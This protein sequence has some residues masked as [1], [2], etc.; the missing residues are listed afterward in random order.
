MKK[1][2]KKKLVIGITSLLTLL[3]GIFLVMNQSN[4]IRAEKS[5]ISSENKTYTEYRS[6][7]LLDRTIPNGL[8]DPNLYITTP[9]PDKDAY[10]PGLISAVKFT[11]IS[12]FELGGTAIDGSGY[13]WTW[14]FNGNGRTGIGTM[15]GYLGGMKRIPFFVD[16]NI[17]FTYVVS[18]YQST[19]AISKTGEIYAWGS[20]SA[21]GLGNGNTTDQS[22]PQKINIPLEKDEKIVLIDPSD[23]AAGNNTTV[24]AVTDKGRVFAWGYGT[25][26]MIP[27][28]NGTNSSPLE[29][30]SITALGE[31]NG[32]IKKVS[33]GNSQVLMLMNNGKVFSWGGNN[34]GSLGLGSSAGSG[35]ATPSEISSLNGV[36]IIDISTGYNHS[37]A[38]G[39]NGKVYQWG[40]VYGYSGYGASNIGSPTIV[41]YDATSAD[42]VPIPQ[43][44]AAGM[45]SGYIIDQHGRFWTWGRN[46]YYQFMQDGPLYGNTST[47]SS[48]DW[49]KPLNGKLD[50]YL[51]KATQVP[52]SLG[53]G[54]TQYNNTVPKAP[55]FSGYKYSSR[56][57]MT[58]SGYER[59][60]V[61]SDI[62]D[63]ASKKHPTIYDKKYYQTTGVMESI[64]SGANPT[65]QK[66][67]HAKVYLIDKDRRRLVYV[68]RKENETSSSTLSGNYYVAEDSYAGNWIVNNQTTTAL[69]V[70]VTEE[71]SVPVAKDDEKDW[72]SLAIGGEQN[73]F[74]G[75]QGT[76]VPY[77]ADLSPYESSMTI[78]DKSG[79][80]YKQSYNG[81]G[82]IAW[83]WDYTPAY[84][85]NSNG[86]PS[87]NGLYDSYV[88]EL[89]F[90]RGAPRVNPTTI[91]ISSPLKKIYKSDINQEQVTDV[92]ITLGTSTISSQLN[93][94]INPELK[95]AKY[96]KIPFDSLDVNTTI[97]NPT[98][99][100]FKN[101]YNSSEDLGYETGDLI[102]LN[103]WSENDLIN[104]SDTDTKELS[105]GSHIVVRDNCI[106]WVMTATSGYNANLETVS[107]KEYTN[108]YTD[109][110]LYHDGKNVNS[111]NEQVY[112]ATDDY[113]KKTSALTAGEDPDK[114]GLP[115]DKNGKVIE[116]PTFGYDET[117]TRAYTNADPEYMS[118]EINYYTFVPGQENPVVLKLNDL[119][120]LKTE[121]P[122]NQYVHTFNY[123]RDDKMWVTITY[124]GRY[125]GKTTDISPY[126]M[127]DLLG[128]EG[129][130]N[131]QETVKKSSASVTKTL[132]RTPGEVENS[133]PVYFK[134]EGGANNNLTSDKKIQFD[135]I[136]DT[137]VNAMEVIIY[138]NQAEIYL[139]QVIVNSNNEVLIPSSGYLRL[140]NTD[141]SASV[142]NYNL[143]VNS[144]EVEND[145]AFRKA[146]LTTDSTNDKYTVQAILPEMYQYY[147]YRIS[148]TEANHAS[149]PLKR[150]P[151]EVLADYSSENKYYITIYLEPIVSESKDI[152][153]YNWDYKL[154]Q[155]G[156]IEM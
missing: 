22:T 108:Y 138:Y 82:N 144:G 66:A 3:L 27:G 76:E 124:K 77:V 116:N 140:N 100:D 10:T 129:I 154:N 127:D 122:K 90:M 67:A 141:G 134:V 85:S 47:V 72:I 57:N 80:I 20:N 105:D 143:K 17:Q 30:T 133:Q 24:Y 32:G 19:Y 121:D 1:K 60:G 153:F 107:R 95:E 33:L 29:L 61:W 46:N 87:T 28:K 4:H 147:G 31:A 114:Y 58:F 45:Y 75:C 150:A 52:K 146:R 65:Q 51:T 71:T 25:G 69:P 128:N 91:E 106:L 151:E 48:Y 94:T 12:N 9:A 38:L 96:V 54:D 49:T 21:G 79:N 34:F 115:L 37:M 26:N 142:S 99:D 88:Y 11:S 89:M 98:I 50:N 131:N 103:G 35:T 149:A 92:K 137:S 93:I 152:P 102:D 104:K 113:V 15:T 83:G 139:R 136:S 123:E 68:V 40:Q 119:K 148:T 74:T 109:T 145:I 55:V 84:D 5:E 110:T 86:N 7:N 97:E 81:S 42:Y 53:D 111:P 73:D 36:E 118:K 130:V 16:N 132:T 120:Y 23:V 156:K 8:D 41:E 18:G 112:E 125:I 44:I 2:N 101:A 63:L 64:S 126:K 56:F 6:I 78:L 59:S 135:T 39:A 62:D 117:T 155:F 70:G 14:G 43:K 13:I